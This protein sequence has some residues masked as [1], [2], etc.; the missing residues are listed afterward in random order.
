MTVQPFDIGTFLVESRAKRNGVEAWLV[1]VAYLEDGWR[2]PRAVC[3]CPDY[4]GKNYK[5]CDHIYAVAAFLESHEKT[6]KTTQES[7]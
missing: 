4:M 2:R 6:T 3:G 1:D 7:L 5:R